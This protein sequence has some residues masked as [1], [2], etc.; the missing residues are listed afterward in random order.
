[1]NSQLHQRNLSAQ[2]SGSGEWLLSHGTFQNW[3]NASED[4]S[5]KEIQSKL[6]VKG[7]PGAGKS[8]LCSAAINHVTNRLQG[9]CLY[10]FYRFDDQSDAGIGVDDPGYSV[11]AAALLVD[12][13]F[14][15]FWRQDRRIAGPVGA[16]I[17]TVEKNTTTLA[18]VVR[19]ILKY[20][21]Q[22]S[23]EQGARSAAEPIILYLFLDGLDENRNPRAANEI[24]RL[25]H[26]LENET[27]IMRKLWISSRDTNVLRQDLDQCTVINIDD[28]AEADV[29]D[30]LTKVVPKFNIGTERDCEINGKPRRTP[31][32]IIES[33]WLC[34][35]LTY[36]V[37]DWILEKL[38]DRAK[39]NFLYASLM[40]ERL[41]DGAFS[42]DDIMVL[43][44]SKVPNNFAEMY[45]RVFR[46]Y[47]E[48][49]HKYIR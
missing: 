25:L 18:E 40:V 41:Q 44:T 2:H 9:V 49:Q 23:Q 47:Q 39:G 45:R 38:Q 48:D 22:H 20:G 6:W 35:L 15:Y 36:A 19:L 29:K 46:Q 43:I 7:S 27:P 32:F 12:Q 4:A 16:F 3:S 33:P 30:Y 24:L 21:H 13:L 14:R 10:Y 1:M 5:E 34:S 11:R 37:D 26:G 8:V 28:H 31:I 42:V 17:E